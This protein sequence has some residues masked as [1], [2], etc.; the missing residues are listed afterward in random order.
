MDW[1]EHV[2]G[3]S[4]QIREFTSLFWLTLPTVLT[5][6]KKDLPFLSFWS[7][8]GPGQFASICVWTVTVW[9]LY[10]SHVNLYFR[11]LQEAQDI[12]GV[13]FNYE[14]FEPYEYEDDF[15]D[16]E[17]TVNVVQN[18]HRIGLGR[19]VFLPL[20]IEKNFANSQISC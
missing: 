11:A 19:A 5:L 17:V 7:A 12:F 14:E 18:Y 2:V 20:N 1:S 6:W 9:V 16:E 3:F 13:D 4:Q 8:F 15:D 10:I